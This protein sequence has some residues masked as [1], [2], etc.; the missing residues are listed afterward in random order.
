MT[1]TTVLEPIKIPVLGYGT[2]LCSPEEAKVGVLA[3]LEAGYRHID[4]A[5]VYKNEEGVGAALAE[6]GLSRSDFYITTK[7]FPGGIG[8]APVKDY[9]AVLAA[10]KA[11]LAKLQ[12]SYVDLYLIHAPL[13]TAVRL[14]QWKALLQLQKEGLVKYIGVSNYGIAHLEE[15]QHAQLPLPSCNQLELHPLAQQRELLRWMARHEIVPIAYSSL[16]PLQSWRS[17]QH[18]RASIANQDTV[19]AILEKLAVKYAKSSAQILLRWGLQHHFAILPKSSKVKRIQEN[20]LLFD[21]EILPDDM[22]ALDSLDQQRVFAW[23]NGFDP[24]TAP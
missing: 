5:E 9:H 19:T 22:N 20:A 18:G 10:C 2:Y 17:E 24:T 1:M 23:P 8:G 12:L 21:F 13:A 3:A 16:V 7:V 15:L 6:S 4:T 11:S 14:D